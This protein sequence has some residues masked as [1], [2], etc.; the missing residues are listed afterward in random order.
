MLWAAFAI[1]ARFR[2]ALTSKCLCFRGQIVVDWVDVLWNNEDAE[3]TAAQGKMIDRI[4]TPIKF[5][6]SYDVQ[7]VDDWIK[8]AVK[9]DKEPL[10]SHE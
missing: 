4:A 10:S 6:V 8:M 2:M 3:Y 1:A 7:V 5:V 9:G